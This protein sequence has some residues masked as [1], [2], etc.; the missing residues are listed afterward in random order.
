MSMLP[1]PTGNR[2]RV[3]VMLIAFAAAEPSAFA[4]GPAPKADRSQAEVQIGLCS[5]IDHI[6]QAL[7]LQPRAAAPIEV[8]QFDDPAISLFARGLR[9]RLRVASDGRAEL[10]LKVANQACAR[11]GAKLPPSGKGKCEYDVYGTTT[12]GTVS[13]NTKL[14]AK[15]T[16]ELLAGRVTLANA[17]SP[18]QVRYLRETVGVWPLP[19]DI[20]KLGPMQVRTYRTAGGLYDVDISHLPNGERHAEIS[21]K[22]ALPD[23]SSTMEMLKTE[24]QRAGVEMC[25]DQSSQAANKLRSL[26]R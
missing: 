19:D 14:G 7:N 21:G 12:M 25:V 8:W 13:L 18:S 15:S 2:T 10:T 17:L 23:A 9:F 24:L 26:L 4:A 20:R 22:V 3:L 6:V 11:S 16:G 5:P 1:N